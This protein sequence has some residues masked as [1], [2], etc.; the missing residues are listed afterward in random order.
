MSN[1]LAAHRHT[2]NN[3]AEIEAS[4]VC[5]CCSCMEIFA[6]GE[7]VAWAGL[8]FDSFNDPD[9]DNAGTAVCPKCGSES[10][11]GDKSGYEINPNFL[12]LM[13]QAWFRSTIVHRPPKKP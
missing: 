12:S 8:D 7:I 3:R 2:S 13:N 4:R 5:G 6:P 1:L 9:C 10:V 11:I